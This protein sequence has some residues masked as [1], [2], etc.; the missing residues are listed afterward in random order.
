MITRIISRSLGL[1][2]MRAS[3]RP[4]DY[5]CSPK[6]PKNARITRTITTTIIRRSV[7]I[8]DLSFL[9]E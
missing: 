3:R 4:S 5:K 2:K 8:P 1:E 9:K 7:P 6:I